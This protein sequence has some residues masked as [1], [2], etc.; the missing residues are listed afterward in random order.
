[1]KSLTAVFLS[2]FMFLMSASAQDDSPYNTSLKV[3][4]PVILG[5]LGLGFLGLALIKTAIFHF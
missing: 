4:G 1:M 2:F 5:S 3:D